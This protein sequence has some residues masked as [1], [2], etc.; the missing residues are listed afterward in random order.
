MLG[1]QRR[2]RIII[3]T[4]LRR[5]MGGLGLVVIGEGWLRDCMGLG[6]K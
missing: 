3:Q 2:S 6:G 5:N 4:L 1:V